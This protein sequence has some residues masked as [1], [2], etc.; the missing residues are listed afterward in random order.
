VVENDLLIG[1][2]Y[3]NPSRRGGFLGLDREKYAVNQIWITGHAMSLHE[4]I[5]RAVLQ[6]AD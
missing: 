4:K 2:G 1:A 6:I 5:D 3:L